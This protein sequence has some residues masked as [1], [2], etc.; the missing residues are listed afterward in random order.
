[1]K[2]FLVIPL[3]LAVG[4][5][6]YANNNHN[7]HGNHEGNS[8][9]Q[10]EMSNHSHNTTFKLNENIKFERELLV[11]PMI[12]GEVKNGVR[13]FNLE[14]GKGKWE[15]LEGKETETYGY[16]GA[17]LGPVL[18]LNSGEKTKI[19]I[20]N[21]LTEETTVHWHGAIVSQN[22]DG[23]HNADILPNKIKSVEFTLNQP[24]STLWF[25]PHPMHKTAGQVYKGLA[26][27]IFLEDKDSKNLDIPKTYGFND[28]P[29]VIQDK[30]LSE[31][32]QL[33]YSTTHMEKI[34]G[35]SG[36]YLM[37]NGVISPYLNIPQGMT[38]LRIVNGS[39]AT[40]F[41]IDL[42]GKEFYQIAS[43]GGFLNS[44]IKL[45][46]LTLVP[47][48]RAEIVVDS[49]NFK[50][51]EYLY[52]NNTRALEFRKT[53]EK[54]LSNIPKELVKVPEIKDNIDKLNVRNF[55]LKTTSKSNTINNEE[56]DMEKMNFDVKKGEKEIWSITNSNG[57][58][59]M[60]HPF[61]VHG[62]QFRVLERDG[63]KP[64]LNEQG[65]KDTINIRAGEN[66]KILIEYK[67]DGITVYHCHILEHEEM[68]M[69]GQF[70]IE[71]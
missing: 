70:Y 36:G 56:Y 54:S 38:R 60:P 17:I 8:S 10:M 57:M 53:E 58:M 15:F 45:E 67:T 19:N 29:L 46:K 71:K 18:S 24:S 20:K 61:H 9:N 34:H 64:P 50:D 14:A 65:F 55:V 37:I 4:Y 59:D 48:E 12:K 41:D 44:P 7:S 66:V 39:N 42:N 52:I 5:I 23:V 33:Q 40:N 16:N 51:K 6:S 31:D 25:H 11:P 69:M 2:K 68:G 32:G 35:K 49:K 28:F 62:A 26:G 27:L 21:N 13:V 1:M 43:D 63:K 22:V 30:K 3:M 47:G